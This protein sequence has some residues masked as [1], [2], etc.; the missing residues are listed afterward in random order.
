MSEYVFGGFAVV[1]W[2][3]VIA[4]PLTVM[5]WVEERWTGRGRGNHKGHQGHKGSRKS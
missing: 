2:T 1:F 4:V 5:A 3:C